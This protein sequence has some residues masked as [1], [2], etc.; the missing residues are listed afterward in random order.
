MKQIFTNN[1]TSLPLIVNNNG[2]FTYHYAIWPYI[3]LF[4]LIIIVWIFIY[5]LNYCLRRRHT[6]NDQ[7]RLFSLNT[8]QRS[9][10]TN[11]IRNTCATSTKI[12]PQ[13]I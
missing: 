4:T 7:H 1:I 2:S 9:Y 10:I 3:C 6:R 5:L 8:T 13:N 12:S 11:S